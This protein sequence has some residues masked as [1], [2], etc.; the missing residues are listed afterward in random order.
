VKCIQAYIAKP[1]IRGGLKKPLWKFVNAEKKV[2]NY[3]REKKKD[4]QASG[5]AALRATT[6]GGRLTGTYQTSKREPH[7]EIDEVGHVPVGF[8]VD[9]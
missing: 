1:Y 7:P 3:F 6:G 5:F 4:L 2:E 9:P 8:Q